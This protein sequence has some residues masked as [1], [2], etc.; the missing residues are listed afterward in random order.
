MKKGEIILIAL[1]STIVFGGMNEVYYLFNFS[2]LSLGHLHRSIDSYEWSLLLSGVVIFVIW[3]LIGLFFK[4][5]IMRFD[6]MRYYFITSMIIFVIIN[7]YLR[8]MWDDFLMMNLQGEVCLMSSIIF[9]TYLFFYS[10]YY[11]NEVKYRR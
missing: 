7:F 5:L 2:P 3:S 4:R 8:Y 10:I 11:G 9:S 6:K 1:L